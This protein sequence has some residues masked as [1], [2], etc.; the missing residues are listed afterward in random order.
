MRALRRGERRPERELPRSRRS[1][2]SVE[3]GTPS[4]PPRLRGR[5]ALPARARRRSGPRIRPFSP[6]RRSRGRRGPPSR[7]GSACPRA[8]GRGRGSGAAG[9]EILDD[10]RLR[11]VDRHGRAAGDEDRPPGR[12]AAVGGNAKLALQTR[13]RLCS[14]DTQPELTKAKVAPG[15]RRHGRARPRRCPVAGQSSAA[16]SDPLV[17]RAAR[18][19]GAAASHR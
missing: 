5:S 16:R 1:R 12:R 2:H 13:H 3:R 17:R 8:E 6:R 14:L 4:R 18:A 7:S 9:A 10:H 15:P 11:P 19:P